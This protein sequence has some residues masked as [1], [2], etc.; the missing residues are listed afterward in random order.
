MLVDANG[1]KVVI[2]NNM[3]DMNA[4]LKLSFGEIDIAKDA[5]KGSGPMSKSA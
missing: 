1:S 3:S 5:F 4:I 2:K